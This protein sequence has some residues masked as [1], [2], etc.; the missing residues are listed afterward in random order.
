MLIVSDATDVDVGVVM[1]FLLGQMRRILRRVHDPLGDSNSMVSN[2][3]VSLRLPMLEM[4]FICA[5]R[6]VVAC[7]HP[8]FE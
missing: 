7:L 6:L 5:K 8:V 3:S 2:L 1:V 4:W